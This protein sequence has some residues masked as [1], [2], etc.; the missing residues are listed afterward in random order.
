[1]ELEKLKIKINEDIVNSNL[2]IDCIYYVLKD[3]YRDVAEAYN[4]YLVNATQRQKEGE[5]ENEK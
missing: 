5:E 1:M 3:I 4:N 2:K